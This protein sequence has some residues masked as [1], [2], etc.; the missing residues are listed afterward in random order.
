MKLGN[1]VYDLVVTDIERPTWKSVKGLISPIFKFSVC[2]FIDHSVWS[3]GIGSAYYSIKFSLP[4]V[5]AKWNLDLG[6]SVLPDVSEGKYS[7]AAVVW[8]CVSNKEIEFIR[9]NTYIAMVSFRGI[10]LIRFRIRRYIF[11]IRRY[12]QNRGWE[13]NNT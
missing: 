9:N 3:A 2:D 11:R 8:K 6:E 12:M 7:A 1:D 13:W 5:C 10:E 4:K